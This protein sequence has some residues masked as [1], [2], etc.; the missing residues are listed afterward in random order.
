MIDE[1]Q[2]NLGVVLKTVGIEP[3][4]RNIGLI[5]DLI[6]TIK[7]VCG[8]YLAGD[9]RVSATGN[10]H[11]HLIHPHES[12][13]VPATNLLDDLDEIRRDLNM[14]N[15][16]LTFTSFVRK[17]QLNESDALKLKELKLQINQGGLVKVLQNAA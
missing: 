12:S 16:D 9:G 13:P 6:Y 3:L 17:Y 7:V 10:A 5:A 1:M 15:I 4:E 8:F 14:P 2:L 11:A